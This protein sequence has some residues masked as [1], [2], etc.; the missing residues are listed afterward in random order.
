MKFKKGELIIGGFSLAYLVAFFIYFFAAGNYE[1]LGYIGVVSIVFILIASTIRRTNFDYV[2]LWG[3]S[4][5]GL[6]HMLGGSL[7]IGETALYGW[8]IIPLVVGEGGM[9]ILKFDQ[10]VHF[11]GFGVAALVAYHL[12]SQNWRYTGSRKLLFV[13]SVLVSAGFGVLNEITEFLAA[14]FLPETGVGDFYNMGLDLIFN[15]AGAIV[16][17]IFVYF[18][19]KKIKF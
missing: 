16:A 2:T 5:W 1:F 10:V 17:M 7:R 3:L 8:K 9:Y 11:Y 13:F 15:T 12:L 6:L 19:E 14:V 18:R 4:I